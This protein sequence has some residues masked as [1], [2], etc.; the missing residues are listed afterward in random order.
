LRAWNDAMIGKR[1]IELMALLLWSCAG[2]LV[3][4]DGKTVLLVGQS[5]DNHPPAT[6]EYMPGVELLAGLLQP[7][8]GLTVRVVNGDEP[9][10]D[11]P[12]L[13]SKAD[14]AVLFLAEGARWCQADPRRQEALARL[15][16]RGGGLVGLHWAIGTKASEPIA[17][18]LKLLGGCHGGP[19]RKYTVVDTELRVAD[20]A[21]PIATGLKDFRVRDELYYRLKFID[22]PEGI[23]PL[24]QATIDGRAE[25]VAWSYERPGGGRS[26]G[27]SGLHFHGN[28]QR[29]EYR[30]LI[31]QAVLW[32][33]QLSVN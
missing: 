1:R 21:H 23:R 28:W 12:E 11:G 10:T 6:H 33:L 30:T 16:A 13:L 18:F 29:A 9:W 25:T 17:P 8:E 14:G 15:A 22:P 31:K 5:H 24:L 4:A 32:T 20:P 19:D 3:A 2:V 7:T 26:F 27:F